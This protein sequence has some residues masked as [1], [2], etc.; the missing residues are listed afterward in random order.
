MSNAIGAG[1][2]ISTSSD[3]IKWGNY[4]FKS[5][6]K[7]ITDVMLQN[8]GTD[9]DGDIIN[10]GLATQYTNHLDCFIGHQG[11]IDS[12]SS[13]FGYAPRSDALIIILSN[14]NI[15]ANQLMESLIAWVSEPEE[16]YM[17]PH[18]EQLT[19]SWTK[20]LLEENE[21]LKFAKNYND[22]HLHAEKNGYGPFTITLYDRPDNNS[23]SKK[24]QK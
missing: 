1:S 2:V 12:F 7:M 19:W 4:L 10:L 22:T 15:D 21:A 8:Y 18:T 5:A 20:R 9:P 11:G 13:F 3:L 24:P 14:N 6:P 23:V 17:Q 16:T